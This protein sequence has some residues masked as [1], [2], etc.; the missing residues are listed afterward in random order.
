MKLC[1]GQFPFIYQATVVIL[2]L[3]NPYFC[4][5]CPPPGSASAV[6][7]WGVVQTPRYE[8]VATMRYWDAVC[9]GKMVILF[10]WLDLVGTITSVSFCFPPDALCR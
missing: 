7:A 2:G 5:F 9:A 4:P 3:A 1:P 10:C 8:I 6:W